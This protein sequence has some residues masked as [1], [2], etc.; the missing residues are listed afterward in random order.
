MIGETIKR[1]LFMDDSPIGK[2]V[3]LNNV[4]FKVIGVLSRRGANMMGMDQDDIVLAPWQT[5]KA[6]VSSSTL[7]SVN[8]SAGAAAN[9]QLQDA[10]K[11][12]S[13]SQLFPGSSQ[14]SLYP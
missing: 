8:Q 1:E 11:V 5:I 9:S 4:S 3:R 10:T 13:L 6:R 2:E 12:N 14:A 7:S